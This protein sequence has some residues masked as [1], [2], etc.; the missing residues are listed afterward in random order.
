MKNLFLITILIL[1]NTEFGFCQRYIPKYRS[2]SQQEMMAIPMMMAQKA[3][4][5]RDYL[6]NLTSKI[7]ELRNKTND[8]TIDLYLSKSYKELCQYYNQ[9]LADNQ[10]IAKIRAKERE[11]NLTLVEMEKSNKKKS[12]INTD[13][14]NSDDKSTTNNIETLY[15]SAIQKIN[16]NDF[17]GSLA[18]I[19]NLIRID[20]NVGQAYYLR[21]YLTLYYKKNPEVAL[22][23]FTT[24]LQM[25]PDDLNSLFLRAECYEHLGI[26]QNAIVDYTQILRK[27][28]KSLYAYYR[29]GICKANLDDKLGA[30]KDYDYIITNSGNQGTQFE[31]L[32]TVYNNKAYC[33]VG[34]NKPKEG[35]PFANESLKLDESFWYSWDTRGEIYYKI[36]EYQKCI[37]DMNHAISIEENAN[38]FYYR[39]LA[40]Y[41]L[42]KKNEACDDLS[43]A[44]ELGQT[45]AY[46]AIRKYCQ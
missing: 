18:D 1:I 16:N 10:I 22:K 17:E 24:N 29:R 25:N 2:S 40:Q 3:Q 19:N 37:N 30:I 39:G 9:D 4:D 33:L 21:G 34:L 27:D 43:K 35:L 26:N 13:Q 23:D 28:S 6:D 44:G 14:K 46:E 11:I 45:E 36:G 5:T 42:N 20:P 38:S 41:K 7:L 15:N 32:A 12:T 31:E 8:S